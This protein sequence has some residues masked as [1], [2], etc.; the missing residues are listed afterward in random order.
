[1]SMRDSVQP[2]TKLTERELDVLKLAANG[3]RNSEIAQL[4]KISEYTVADHMKSVLK[5][6]G[7]TTRVE[8][9]VVACRAGLLG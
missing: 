5:R 7:A 8:A 4:L 9:A 2:E 3:L 1:M 6:L